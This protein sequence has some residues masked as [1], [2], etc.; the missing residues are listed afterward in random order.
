MTDRELLAAA[1]RAAGVSAR[2]FA[3]DVVVRDER[4]VRRWTAGAIPIPAVVVRKLRG[5]VGDDAG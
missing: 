1:I 3:E 5:L 2:R 4:T